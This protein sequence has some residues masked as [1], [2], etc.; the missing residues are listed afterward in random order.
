MHRSVWYEAHAT[1]MEAIA[2]EKRIKKWHRHWK[3]SLVQAMNP[4]WDD[5]FASIAA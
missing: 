5:L 4:S 2:R 3:V 1:A